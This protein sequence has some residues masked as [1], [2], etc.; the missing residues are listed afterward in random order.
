MTNLA[1]WHASQAAVIT[2][3]PRFTHHQQYG[4]TGPMAQTVS[5]KWGPQGKVKMHQ[6]DSTVV[7]HTVQ[8][9]FLLDSCWKIN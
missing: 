6:V 1:K 9:S 8:V 7:G 2:D 4:K 3:N 5:Q